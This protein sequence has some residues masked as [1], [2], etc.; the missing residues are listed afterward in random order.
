MILRTVELRRMRENIA[1]A[2]I[3][4]F[5]NGEIDAVYLFV[6]EFQERDGADSV[7]KRRL[8]P[9]EVP[10]T[11]E[12]VDYIYEQKPEE[13][14]GTLLPRYIKLQ[15]YRAHARIGRG[16]ARGA[17]DGDGRGQ[18]QRLRRDRQADVVY[19]PR[20]PGEHHAR[21]YRNCERRGCSGLKHDMAFHA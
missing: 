14:L 15:I 4:R 16:R 19:E 6:N 18:L 12:Q 5:S 9:I 2:I 8:L 7:V 20:A 10:K 17:H 11:Q 21:N 1:D 3:E 13:L